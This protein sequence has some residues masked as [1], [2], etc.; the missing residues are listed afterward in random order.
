MEQVL[1]RFRPINRLDARVTQWLTRHS[2]Q[3]VRIK[4]PF[5]RLTTQQLLRI[6][7]I[8]D[9][10]STGNLHLTTRRRQSRPGTDPRQ[11]TAQGRYPQF[12]R[13]EPT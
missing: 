13:G 9:E 1:P 8:S 3:M 11:A 5:G 2:V 10:Y 4:L 7:A 6:A 12:S